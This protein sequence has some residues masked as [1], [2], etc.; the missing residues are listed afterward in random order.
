ML[1][2]GYSGRMPD[3][4]ADIDPKSLCRLPLVQ[5]EVLDDDNQRAYDQLLDPASGSLRGLQGPGGIALHSPLYAS[6]SRPVLRYFRTQ[7]ALPVRV[8]ELAILTA[9]READSAVEWAAHVPQALQAGV[10][11]ATVDVIAHRRAVTGLE[12]TDAAVIEFG[13]E[14]FGS[15]RVASATYARIKAL[16]AP[17]ELVDLVALMG[18]YTAAAALLT[19]F[20]MQIDG[21]DGPRL[22]QA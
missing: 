9:A 20:D 19:A 1:P 10:P 21:V 13:R 15:H 18:Y 4:P 7:C 11:T 3:L 16:F 5:R 22:P 17:R 8:R 12:S 6:A 2:R 14:L